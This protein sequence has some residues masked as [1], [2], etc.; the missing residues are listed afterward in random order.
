LYRVNVHIRL[1]FFKIYFYEL[2]VECKMEDLSH[3]A[4]TFT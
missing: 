4:S 3:E 2:N 1:A